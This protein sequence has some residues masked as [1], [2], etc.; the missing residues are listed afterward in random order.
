M[1]SVKDESGSSSAD[2]GRKSPLR[3]L[4]PLVVVLCLSILVLAMGWERQ[5]SFETLARHHDDLRQFIAAHQATALAGY[6]GLYIAVVGLSLPAGAYLT[7]IGGI[8]FGTLIGGCAAVVGA[9]IGAI[10]IFSIAKSAFGEH[11]VRKAGPA[12]AKVAQGFRADA[13]SYLLFLRLVP[14]FPFWLVN[15][16]SALCGLRLATFAAGTALGIMPATFVFASVGSGLASIMTAQ[17]RAYGACL[18]A[19]RVDCRL[20]FQAADAL[21]PQLLAALVALGLL[22]LVPVVVKRLRARNPSTVMPHESGAS[23][24]RTA[25]D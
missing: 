3:R 17:E 13:L 11:L 7:I 5:I 25:K 9:S 4:T 15:L 2:G 1:M 12:A 14:I 8:L 18:A 10:L 21:T 22:A 24:N 6:I 23:S 20:T 16:V 19:G